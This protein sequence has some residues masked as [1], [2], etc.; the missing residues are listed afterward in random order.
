MRQ[1]LALTIVA[2]MSVFALWALA[3]TMPSGIPHITSIA[4]VEANE[5]EPHTQ[6]QQ[7]ISN[8]Q[9]SPDA[10]TTHGFATH[11]PA[12]AQGLSPTSQVDPL[13]AT[14]AYVNERH[15]CIPSRP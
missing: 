2:L 1:K 3:G 10:I 9:A 15:R 7:T 14:K 6:T 13:E 11:P 5:Y 8:R 4:N 12:D